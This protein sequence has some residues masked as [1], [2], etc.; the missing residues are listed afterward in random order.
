M[1]KLK[2]FLVIMGVVPLLGIAIAGCVGQQSQSL[3]LEIT[4][5]QYEADVTQYMV[6]VSGIVSPPTA[7]V[8][9]NGVEVET[10]EDGT[11]STSVDLD[12]GENTIVVNATV[13]GQEPATKTVTVTRILALEITSPQDKA[14]VTQSP[15]TV[16][17]AVSDPSAVVMV[18]G[19]EVETAEDGT[20]ST[21]VKLNYVKNTI[22][23][24]AT[25]EG[26]ESVTR[27]LTVIYAISE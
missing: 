2:K 22:V 16:S 1:S 19:L 21:S 26:Q 13:E 18:N 17:G 20:F 7:V 4:S 5:H 14:E 15:I 3:V 9:V 8:T 10:V 25:V 11:F 12:Y 24:N 27:T 23:V 6:T